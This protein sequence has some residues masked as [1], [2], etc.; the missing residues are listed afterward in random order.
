MGRL[1]KSKVDE[2]AKLREDGYTQ[3]EIA[4]R[5]HV[6]PRTVRKYDP[7]RQERS[8]E[9]SVEKRLS[10]LEGA[11]STCWHYIDLLYWAM[12]NSAIGECL[13]TKTHVCPRC[14]GRLIYNEDKVTYICN[15]CGHKFSILSNWCY[16]CLSIAEFVWSDEIDDPVCP[17]CGARRHQPKT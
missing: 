1:A 8:E 5:L 2:I 7:S 6:H 14:L 15:K 11:I 12:H 3:K 4:E 10:A 17:K 16:N 13:E 9:R